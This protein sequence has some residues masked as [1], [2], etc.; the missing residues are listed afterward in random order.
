[1]NNRSK[2]WEIAADLEA[3]AKAI[4]A[5]EKALDAIHHT[6][7]DEINAIPGQEMV[8]RDMA[9][10]LQELSDKYQAIA[11]AEPDSRAEWE[12]RTGYTEDDFA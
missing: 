12:L 3:A 2:P 11:D 1:M 10:A 8:S 4:L 7:S 9:A 5:A 6:A